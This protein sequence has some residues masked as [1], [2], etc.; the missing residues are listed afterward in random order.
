MSGIDVIA[1]LIAFVL[2]ALGG[3]V[4]V[5]KLRRAGYSD[6][7]DRLHARA[8]RLQIKWLKGMALMLRTPK[9]PGQ[10]RPGERSTYLKNS[11]DQEQP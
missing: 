5:M 2:V 7:L 4:V 11:S 8:V 10:I 3:R 1:P 9:L 6:V